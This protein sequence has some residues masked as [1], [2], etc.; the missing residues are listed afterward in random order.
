M[1]PFLLG[2][3]KV[4]PHS[5]VCCTPGEGP[6]RLKLV[7][8]Q[9]LLEMGGGGTTFIPCHGSDNWG[10]ALPSLGAANCWGCIIMVVQL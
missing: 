9:A 6:D 8:R 5:C 2:D 7:T 4:D 3:L 1:F 10:L